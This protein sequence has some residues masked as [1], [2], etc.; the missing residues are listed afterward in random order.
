[1]LPAQAVVVVVCTVRWC[2]GVAFSPCVALRVCMFAATW[3]TL[4]ICLMLLA[5]DAH[6]CSCRDHVALPGAVCVLVYITGVYASIRAFL[7][8]LDTTPSLLYSRF[9]PLWC[10]S[11]AGCL[12]Q[13]LF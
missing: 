2:H 9:Q 8:F 13:Q 12:V 4:A 3:D 1:V 11:A 5:G 7:L 6:V 10:C